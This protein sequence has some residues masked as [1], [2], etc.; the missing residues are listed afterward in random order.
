ML[1]YVHRGFSDK[2]NVR[3]TTMDT[4]ARMFTAFMVKRLMAT[5]FSAFPPGH[6]LHANSTAYWKD[7]MA[8]VETIYTLMDQRL[9]AT[10]GA[11]IQD[12]IAAHPRQGNNAIEYTWESLGVTEDEI[13]DEFGDAFRKHMHQFNVV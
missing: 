4:C 11:N 7:P 6:V 9:S 12:Y 2:L 10:S 3:G 1:L 5:N 8:F 13:V